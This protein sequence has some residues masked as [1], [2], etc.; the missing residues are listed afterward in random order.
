M[1]LERLQALEN[2]LETCRNTPSFAQILTT[3]CSQVVQELRAMTRL[4]VS[5]AAPLVAMVQK[6]Q[7]W[8]QE[9]KDT[10]VSAIN[11]KVEESVS[12]MRHLQNRQCLQDFHYFP[13][14]LTTQEWD[15]LLHDGTTNVAQKC[16]RVMDRLYKLGLRAPSEATNAMLTT[17]LLLQDSTRFQDALQ[18][19]SSYLTI[20]DMAK[21]FLKNKVEKNPKLVVQNLPPSP[22]VF[23]RTMSDFTFYETGE[24]PGP[25]PTGVTMENLIELH[26]LIPQRSN[27][28][29]INLGVAAPSPAAPSPFASAGQ[30]IAQMFMAHMFAS[31]V[32]AYPKAAS[33]PPQPSQASGPLALPAPP[34]KVP[35]V[36]IAVVKAPP[37]QPAMSPSK[38]ALA[39]MDAPKAEA[40][41]IEKKA[42]DTSAIA[43]NEALVACLQ[44][45]DHDKKEKKDEKD[46]V[47]EK[48]QKQDASSKVQ[49]PATRADPPVTKAIKTL[50]MKRPAAAK[51]A[52]TPEPKPE[53]KS[54]A[55]K[56][57]AASTS[58]APEKKD[59]HSKGPIPSNAKRRKL[60]PEGC[61]RCRHVSGCCD[62]SWVQRG[63]HR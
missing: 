53:G 46:K 22:E 2:Y 20:K 55:L 33:H 50:G 37:S 60:K 52:A 21:N 35:E 48:T 29:T 30:V 17:V 40:E 24:R 7:V 36:E 18:L 12:G 27:R 43:V 38:P 28:K 44:T 42:P 32:H 45:R 26:Q 49:E 31:N 19:R 47:E 39:L 3:Q 5:E 54:K 1:A 62:S 63:Y 13:Y 8:T 9:L 23:I 59:Q 58:L 14:Y 10:L 41:E 4:T 51:S 15:L 61:S 34:L 6:S 57:P 25:L 56:R 11:T 16:N